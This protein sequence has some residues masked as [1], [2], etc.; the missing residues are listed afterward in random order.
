MNYFVI[1]ALGIFL[2][3][4]L[5]LDIFKHFIGPRFHE[6]LKIVPVVLFANLLLGIFFNLSVWYK[7]NN[8]TRYGAAITVMG[9]VITFMVNWIFIPVY[10]YMASAWAHVACYGSMV[11]VSWM[12]GR[13]HYRI[14]YPLKSIGFYIAVAMMIYMISVSTFKTQPVAGIISNTGLLAGFSILVFFR[15]RKNIT[16]FNR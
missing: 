7:L 11:V 5:Y 13:A 3:V 6:G 4:T 14:P 15:E 12:L 9:A 10:G 1:A 8:L 2:V 16:R